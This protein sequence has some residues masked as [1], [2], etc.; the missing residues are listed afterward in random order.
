MGTNRDV[1]DRVKSLVDIA[2][3]VR[4]YVELKPVSGRWM[5]PC[6]FHQE[7]KPSFS[8]SSDKGLFYCF[9]CQASGDV[10]DFY[11][12]IN[13]LEFR[14]ALEAL[15]AEAGIEVTSG[16]P[17]PEAAR[18]RKLR[19]ACLD[20]HVLAERHYRMNLRSG[21][22]QACVGYLKSRG[23]DPETVDAFRLGYALDDWHALEKL[24]LT[25][26]FDRE[27]AVAS[28]LLIKNDKGNVYDR[29]RGRLMFPISDV[30]GRVIAFGGRAVG[31][32]EPKYLNSSDS[33]VYH[34]GEHLF[35]LHQ[36]RGAMAKSRRV[37]L[38]EGYLDVMALHQF[39][40]QEAVGV[41]G[42]ALTADQVKRLGGFARHVD[43]VFDGDRAG[44][45]AA[46]KSVEL[47]LAQGLGCKVVTLPEGQDVD[48]L[49]RGQGPEAFAA[50]L[51]EAPEGLEYS[52]GYVRDEFSP[53]ELLDWSKK[54]L[55]RFDDPSWT[56]Y[57]LPRLASGL[58][59]AEEELRRSLPGRTRSRG[60][61]VG[62]TKGR[63]PAAGN[64]GRAEKGTLGVTPGLIQ[65]PGARRDRELLYFAARHPDY[66]ERMREIGM[67]SVLDTEEA[68]DF[69]A[70]LCQ[71]GDGEVFNRL[72]EGQK[73]FWAQV[74]MQPLLPDSE[75]E[76]LWTDICDYV[77]R[78]RDK[79]R[80]EAI[81]ED[82][83]KAQVAGDNE[84]AAR[85]LKAYQELREG[86]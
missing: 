2:E 4:R 22:G 78:R 14:D 46:F 13:G 40:W 32:G 74:Q 58:G 60:P 86:K 12:R 24:L 11:G 64:G 9:G 30:A 25:E 70:R 62:G 35:G 36:A 1:V 57:F 47:V 21:A 17:D 56:A 50:L 29:F 39:G 16:P 7:T 48:D 77:E 34:K 61:G 5:G 18:E 68:R 44:R 53:G 66:L 3:V 79:G 23:L 45:Q 73:R 6:P 31:E 83:R 85:L 15:A 81:L 71:A 26:G 8:V 51:E 82:L 33:P 80:R 42:T 67:E 54:F 10:I 63:R 19:K 37:L 84:E 65:G 52:L 69:F 28:S 20:M 49:L 59:L 43:L 38:T 55:G 76:A 75:R 27:D 72:N 41:L